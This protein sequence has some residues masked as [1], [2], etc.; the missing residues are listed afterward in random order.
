MNTPEKML[1][2]VQGIGP[3]RYQQITA[4]MQAANEPLVRIFDM[5]VD[6]LTARFRLP[7]HVAEAIAHTKK[8]PH[9][10]DTETKETASA[11]R[12]QILLVHERAELH[13]LV[14]ILG[15]AAP[16]T[17]HVWGNLDLLHQPALGFCGSRNV[18]ERGLQVTRDAAA[19]AANMGWVVVSGHARGVDTTAHL[20][21]LEEGGSTIIVAAEGIDNFKL[22]QELKRIARPDQLLIISEFAPSA[23]WSVINAMRRNKTIVALSDAMIVVESRMEGGTF[24]AGKTALRYRVPLFVTLFEKSDESSAGNAY[25]LQRGAI[26]L[27]KNRET[28]RASL[29]QIK[30]IIGSQP[31][32]EL[33]INEPALEQPLL[34]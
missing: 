9:N 30:N 11:K 19:Q 12:I 1:Q 22:R 17:L 26:P 33:D 27:R 13:R 2:A 32:D 25:F 23:R 29:T 3:K 31:E 15:K 21:V 6:D 14:R 8:P 34:L 7:R 24:D 4:L 16:S 20:A 10:T 18:S 5:P 28:G